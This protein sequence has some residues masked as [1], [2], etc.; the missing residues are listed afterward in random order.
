MCRLPPSICSTTIGSWAGY[1][2]PVPQ[3]VEG[4]DLSPVLVK[5]AACYPLEWIIL[6]VSTPRGA[7]FTSYAQQPS[8]FGTS[9]RIK[10][11]SGVREGDFKL[12]V[13]Y[14]E[15]GGPIGSSSTT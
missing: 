8:H 1:N 3:G 15:T 9:S 13:E 14:N 10:P 2:G 12:Y 4:A 5:M 6:N 7:N 11:S